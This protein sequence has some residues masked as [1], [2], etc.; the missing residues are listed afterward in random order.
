MCQ[1]CQ[2][3]REAGCTRPVDA[4]PRETSTIRRSNEAAHWHL[5]GTGWTCGTPVLTRSGQAGAR[6]DSGTAFPFSASS[7]LWVTG[8][9]TVEGSSSA[10]YRQEA[11][12]RPTS[13]AAKGSRVCAGKWHPR[14]DSPPLLTKGVALRWG[15]PPHTWPLSARSV[16]SITRRRYTG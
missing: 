5:P 10:P 16:H 6:T 2:V 9:L 13:G 3:P 1:V 4:R 12:G 15:H 8:V 11:Q 7:T 14:P